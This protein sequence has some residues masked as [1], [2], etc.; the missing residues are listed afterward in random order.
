MNPHHTIINKKPFLYKFKKELNTLKK[1]ENNTM[2]DSRIS[3]IIHYKY[4]FKSD[5]LCFSEHKGISLNSQT[6]EDNPKLLKLITNE[7]DYYKKGNS[8]H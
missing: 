5:T 3:A 1:S 6:M 7:I 2:M 8:K 4:K